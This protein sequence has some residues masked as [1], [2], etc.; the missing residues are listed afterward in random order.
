MTIVS[1]ADIP[2]LAFW[3]LA[4]KSGEGFSNT[5]E[6][7]SFQLTLL[8][9]SAW[10]SL[11]RLA[12]ARDTKKA[13]FRVRNFMGT[14]PMGSKGACV[15]LDKTNARSQGGKVRLALGLSL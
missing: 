15:S 8:L 14:L 3:F 12:D 13:V 7:L 4:R 2:C 9:K 10:T 6:Y 5:A 1:K 11:R